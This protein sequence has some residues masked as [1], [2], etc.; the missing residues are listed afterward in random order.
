MSNQEFYR[1]QEGALYSVTYRNGL[2]YISSWDTDEPT[3]CTDKL[4]TSFK[5]I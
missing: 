4:P 5:P 3:Y 1:D 2:Y